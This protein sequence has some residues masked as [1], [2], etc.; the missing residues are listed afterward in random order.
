MIWLWLVYFC[1]YL[2]FVARLIDN[3]R[4]DIVCVTL[5]LLWPIIAAYNLIRYIIDIILSFGPE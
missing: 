5:P 4:R 1:G 3:K 2:L